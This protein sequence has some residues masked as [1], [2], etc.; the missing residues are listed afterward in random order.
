VPPNIE[1]QDVPVLGNQSAQ[2]IGH[3]LY[4]RDQDLPIPHLAA[5]AM[6]TQPGAKVGDLHQTTPQI[7]SPSPES[8]GSGGLVLPPL[9]HSKAIE[10]GRAG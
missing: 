8:T 2:I 10:P 5:E 1:H 6:D 9:S 3:V 4:G 7:S